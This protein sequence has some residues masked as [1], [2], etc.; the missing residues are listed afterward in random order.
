VNTQRK[1]R[2]PLTVYYD[3]SCPMCYT[4]MHALRDLDWRGR[5]KLVDCSSR[6]F[7]NSAL[8]QEGVTRTELMGRMHARDPEGRWLIGPDAFEAVYAAAGLDKV[9]RLWGDARLRPLLD[10]VY[11]W[12]ARNR[13]MLSRLGVHRVVGLLFNRA[14]RRMRLK[15]LGPG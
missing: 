5:L 8:A 12:L 7:D 14:E 10:V 4:E 6:A 3:A 15:T 9:A 11:P 2:V 13:W 1:F